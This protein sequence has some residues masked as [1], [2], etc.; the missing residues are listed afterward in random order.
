MTDLVKGYFAHL[1]NFSE[2]LNT[3]PVDLH[4]LYIHIITKIMHKWDF[5]GASP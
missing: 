2:P 4:I 3:V 1:V 5:I